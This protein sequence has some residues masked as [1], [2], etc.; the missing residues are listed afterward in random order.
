MKTIFLT[1]TRDKSDKTIK[2][3]IF[4]THTINQANV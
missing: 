1:K 3:H 2:S 4:E